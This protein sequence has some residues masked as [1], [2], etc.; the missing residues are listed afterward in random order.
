MGRK[1]RG[2]TEALLTIRVSEEELVQLKA[3][4][5]AMGLSMSEWARGVLAAARERE[6]EAA[7]ERALGERSSLITP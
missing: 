2:R 5:Q 4:A 1:S 3:H 6:G 7:A